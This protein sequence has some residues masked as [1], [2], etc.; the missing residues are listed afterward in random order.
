MTKQE[1]QAW[2]IAA[3]LFATLFLVFGSGY[4]TGGVFFPALLH[5]FGW[6]RTRL[7]TLT[8]ALAISAGLSGPLIG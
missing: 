7:S 1:R 8:G 3:S 4:D 5:H 2:F 6:S